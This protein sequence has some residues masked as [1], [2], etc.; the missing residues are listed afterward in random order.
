MTSL[1]SEEAISQVAPIIGD[2]GS[3]FMLDPVTMETATTLGYGHPFALY[4]LGRGGVLGNVDADVITAAFAFFDSGETVC[5]SLRQVRA[6]TLGGCC[7][8]RAVQ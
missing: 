2:L 7:G 3:K 5:R 4:F 6:V 8:T 1:T